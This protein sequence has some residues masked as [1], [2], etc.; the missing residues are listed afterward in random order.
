MKLDRISLTLTKELQAA[1]LK[2]ANERGQPLSYVIR[3]AL[4][5]YLQRSKVYVDHVHPKWGGG[6][7]VK[8]GDK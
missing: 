3:E 1:A 6:R 7:W 4:A 5:A 2:L 8:D